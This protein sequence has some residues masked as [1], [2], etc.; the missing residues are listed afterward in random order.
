MAAQLVH[1]SNASSSAATLGNRAG[2]WEQH[3]GVSGRDLGGP[4]RRNV[5][6]YAPIAVP[7]I[8][9]LL[10]L[11]IGAGCSVTANAKSMRS[12]RALQGNG[13]EA[14]QGTVQNRQ[15]D[16]IENA[17]LQELRRTCSVGFPPNVL[18][19]Q[20]CIADNQAIT[21]AGDDRSSTPMTTLPLLY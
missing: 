19:V 15:G 1:C 2:I 9:T 18:L 17:C 4:I 8:S 21:G 5:D 12:L 7:Q 6:R 13:P 20:R 14:Q 11:K 10:L 16:A 3:G